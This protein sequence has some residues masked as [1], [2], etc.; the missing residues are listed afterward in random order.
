[1]AAE[2]FEVE[3]TLDTN[4]S[5]FPEAKPHLRDHGATRDCAMLLPE[6]LG[7]R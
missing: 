3:V 4:S 1:M 7:P 6:F 2:I 5:G